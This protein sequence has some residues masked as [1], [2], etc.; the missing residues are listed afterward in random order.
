MTVSYNKLLRC[1]GTKWDCRAG[2]TRIYSRHFLSHMSPVSAHTLLRNRVTPRPAA[3]LH[4]F[5]QTTSSDISRS[6]ARRSFSLRASLS[7]LRTSSEASAR[8]E[9][10]GSKGNGRRGPDV[11]NVSIWVEGGRRRDTANA[12]PARAYSNGQRMNG[13]RER[14]YLL[15]RLWHTTDPE[16]LYAVSQRPEA[17]LGGDPSEGDGFSPAASQRPK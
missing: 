16:F 14:T 5:R 4:R 8:E 17:E 15:A 6:R 9:G 13:R 12:S 11:R 10:R 7:L 2:R 1:D 3:A